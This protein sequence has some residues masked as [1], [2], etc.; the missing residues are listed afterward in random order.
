MNEMRD[1]RWVP[2]NFNLSKRLFMPDLWR[3]TQRERETGEDYGRCLTVDSKAPR[4]CSS[5]VEGFYVVSCD[6]VVGIH[7][8]SGAHCTETSVSLMTLVV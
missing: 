3:E 4:C 2:V 8:V 1:E 6:W 5:F 7:V